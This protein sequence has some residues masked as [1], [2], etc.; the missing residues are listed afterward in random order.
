MILDMKCP[1]LSLFD[2]SWLE[3][4]LA[5]TKS[6]LISPLFGS[7]NVACGLLRAQ[8]ADG[9]RM[10]HSVRSNSDETYSIMGKGE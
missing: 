5:P 2:N 4:C 7:R 9:Q 1:E 10:P 6:T 3:K 8:V